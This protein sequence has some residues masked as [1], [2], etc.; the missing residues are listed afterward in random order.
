[1]PPCATSPT[2]RFPA[3]ENY[4][5]IL[6]ASSIFPHPCSNLFPD[7]PRLV[8]KQV[9]RSRILDMSRASEFA[10]SA[11]YMGSKRGLAAFLVEAISSVLPENGIVIDLMCG[12]G[13]ASGAFCRFWKTYASDAQR[14][15]EILARIQGAG[16]SVTR[17]QS[18]LKQLVP[19][20]QEHA[21]HL[22]KRLEFF[23]KWED[24]IFHGNLGPELLED[25]REFVSA[26][27]TYPS[28][29]IRNGWFPFREVER[30]KKNPAQYPY[31]LFSCYFA[32]IYF[33]LREIN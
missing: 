2:S 23:V 22:S 30:R 14:F 6:K 25:Y 18:L 12:S 10:Q 27:P 7:N 5:E 31:C 3:F 13:A 33:G 9:S 28:K 24:R 8:E 17:S 26:L 29:E 11:D 4:L 21:R 1:M 19:R 16:Y 15:C 20:A 32:N